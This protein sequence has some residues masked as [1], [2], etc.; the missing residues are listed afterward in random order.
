MCFWNGEAGD[1]ALDIV[2]G[3]DA[4]ALIQLTRGHVCSAVTFVQGVIFGGAS[5]S[6]TGDVLSG[7]SMC[8]Y[9]WNAW[10]VLV[11]LGGLWMGRLLSSWLGD[12]A[13]YRLSCI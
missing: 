6:S 7:S 9:V 10:E 12:M 8:W 3:W 4:L 5:E 11:C 13:V 2:L 1:R